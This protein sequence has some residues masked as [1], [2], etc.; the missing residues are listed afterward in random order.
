MISTC[1]WFFLFLMFFSLGFVVGD[2]YIAN[3]TDVVLHGVGVFGWGLSLW[4]LGRL[5]E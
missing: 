1:R 3:W 2:I 5:E 4:F